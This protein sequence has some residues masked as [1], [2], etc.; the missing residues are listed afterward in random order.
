MVCAP[1]ATVADL[2]E[3]RPDLTDDTYED[4][5]WQASETL[6][7]LSARQ[8]SGGCS[9]TAVVG[10]RWRDSGPGGP[11]ERWADS[12]LA[13]IRCGRGRPRVVYVPG[14]PVT[15]VVSVTVGGVAVGFDADLSVGRVWLTSGKGFPTDGSA[16]ITY[17]HGLAP[18]IGGQRSAVMLALELAKAWVGD[19]KCKLPRRVESIQREGVTIGLLNNLEMLDK[20]R[21][22]LVEVDS[23]LAAI[24]PMR[25]TARP[26]VWSP[27]RVRARRKVM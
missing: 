27:D 26:T 20:G 9:S 10:G 19:T 14:G 11:A 25:M 8:F 4:L 16:A 13:Y 2:P 7:Q 12:T 24:N 1:W 18:P 3:K 15:E 23:W 6:Y 5:L 21:T 22:G 17:R